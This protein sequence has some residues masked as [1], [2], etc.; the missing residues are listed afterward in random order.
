M[1]KYSGPLEK[2]LELIEERKLQISEISL[3]QVTDD[4]LRYLA[5]LKKEGELQTGRVSERE[6]ARREGL[7]IL[8]D[9]VAVASRLILIKSK[10]LLPELNLTGE[11]EAEIHDLEYRLKLY[12]GLRPAMKIVAKLWRDRREEFS[13]PYFMSIS[14]FAPLKSAP[15]EGPEGAPAR[16]R[17]L[18]GFALRGGDDARAA[19]FFPGRN[20]QAEALAQ[21]LDK[22]FSSFVALIRESQV[23][24]EEVVSM[25]AKI[26]EITEVLKRLS[27]ISLRRISE[28]KS[29]TEVI[30]TFLAV[31]HL[32][33][34][35]LVLLEQ[36]SYLSDI[37]ITPKED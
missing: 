4:F 35:Q 27:K 32:A 5:K 9:F 30:V 22:L 15:P 36:E 20:L 14:A 37:I 13:R 29:P 24:Q 3:A 26:R 19:L 10:S 7:R 34:E 2:L 1:E 16:A 6:L 28:D 17:T 33:R 25:E 12:Q 8:A 18:T 21:S 11:E 23:L 31:L